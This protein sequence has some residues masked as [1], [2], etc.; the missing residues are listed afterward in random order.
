MKQIQSDSEPLDNQGYWNRPEEGIRWEDQIQ[1]GEF[2][3]MPEFYPVINDEVQF[4][5]GTVMAL[6]GSKC[7]IPGS[8]GGSGQV[9]PSEICL[10]GMPCC[11]GSG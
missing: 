9:S 5:D 10:A 11:N 8:C 1:V 2:P 6:S 3:P 4:P 7:S